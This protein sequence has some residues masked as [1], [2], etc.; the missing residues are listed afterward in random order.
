MIQ[1]HTSRVFDAGHLHEFR[2]LDVWTVVQYSVLANATSE[3]TWGRHS[4]S[5]VCFMR[6]A[7]KHWLPVD[8]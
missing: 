5:S 1:Y 3:E 6:E 4:R 7:N 8:K 2:H